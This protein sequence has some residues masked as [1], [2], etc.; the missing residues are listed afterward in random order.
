[1]IENTQTTPATTFGLLRHGETEWNSKKMIQGS[2]DSPLSAKGQQ[3]IG[4]WGDTLS[5][6]NWNQIVASDLGR[7]RQTVEILNTRLQLPTTFD[8]RLREQSWGQWEGLTIGFIKENHKQELER[9]VALGWDFSA[10]EGETRASVR[11]RAV[12]T[13]QDLHDKFP[14]QKILIV[15][16]QG[17]I[18]S[19]LYHITGR[20]FL[21]GEDPLIQ[22]NSFHLIT[23]HLHQFNVQKLNIPRS[24]DSAFT[25][26]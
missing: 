23:C 24:H 19:L 13:L 21:P 14:G 4:Q 10:P 26:E 15:C 3:Q 5:Q 20:A 7:V 11:K 8:I 2:A 6:W 17:V 9:Q 1:M 16:H 12:T 22:H 25:R 18:K